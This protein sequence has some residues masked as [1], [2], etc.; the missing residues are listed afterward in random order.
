[1]ICHIAIANGGRAVT[2]GLVLGE[3]VQEPGDYTDGNENEAEEADSACAEAA[4]PF[5]GPLARLDAVGQVHADADGHEECNAHRNEYETDGLHVQ[6]RSGA[7]CSA[8]FNSIEAAVKVALAAGLRSVAAAFSRTQKRGGHGSETTSAARQVVLPGIDGFALV[9]AWDERAN[10]MDPVGCEGSIHDAHGLARILLAQ[11]EFGEPTLGAELEDAMA[12]LFEECG[13]TIA[14]EESSCAGRQ[15]SA[16]EAERHAAEALELWQRLCRGRCEAHQAGRPD[17]HANEDRDPEAKHQS[18]LEDDVHWDA[19]RLHRREKEPQTAQVPQGRPAQRE[20]ERKEEHGAFYDLVEGANTR[21]CHQAKSNQWWKP[22]TNASPHNEALADV[23]LGE[24]NRAAPCANRD[25]GSKDTYQPTDALDA[26]CGSGDQLRVR[27]ADDRYE[28]VT[29][30]D[31]EDDDRDK[32]HQPKPTL[33]D[34]LGTRFPGTR[35]VWQSELAAHKVAAQAADRTERDQREQKHEKRNARDSHGLRVYGCQYL[36]SHSEDEHDKADGDKQGVDEGEP[37]NRTF[38]W[39]QGV[40]A[41]DAATW[42]QEFGLSM[43]GPPAKG[44]RTHKYQAA[45]ADG[46]KEEYGRP[47]AR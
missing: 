44:Q 23:S 30:R 15:Q 47:G 29:D 3:C 42:W 46:S 33:D 43:F 31:A 32:E 17:Q 24:L 6:P 8:A 14:C 4:P 7:Q 27:I 2:S 11:R 21:R 39:H 18:T 13:Q 9:D 40:L 37:A 12:V 26:L 20:Y 41:Q 19:V 10:R 38:D 5:R 45:E 36:I 28:A 35:L 1:V 25:G 16:E 22:K 34:P